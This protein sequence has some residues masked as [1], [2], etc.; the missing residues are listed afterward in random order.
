M[1]KKEDQTGKEMTVTEV[2]NSVTD[3][4]Y[5]F[6]LYRAVDWQQIHVEELDLRGLDDLNLDDMK[7]L[8]N[9]YEH[10]GGSAVFMQETS[11]L[12]AQV[13]AARVTGYPLELLGKLHPKDAIKLK[14]RVYRF[15]YTAE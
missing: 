10:F 12:F 2:V 11:V 3:N 5:R 15:F 7:E 6:A 8:Y 4:V 9:T 14:S 13:A 1:E